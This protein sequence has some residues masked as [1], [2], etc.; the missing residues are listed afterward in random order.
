MAKLVFELNQSLDGYVDH[1]AFGP[2]DPALFRHFTERVRGLTGMV[3][4]RRMY[5]VMRY[6]DEDSP[7]WD[8]D[9]REY[10]AAWRSKPKWVVSRSLKSVGPK[11]TLVADDIESVIRGMK[12]ELA[13][14]IEV[15]GPE[16]AQ[17]LTDLGLVDEYRLYIHPVVLGRGKPFFAGPRPR[18]RL[19]A[20]DVI[21]EDVIRLT[22]VPA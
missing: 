5:E 18:L 20:S 1:L 4:G 16:L 15:A 19:V 17:S 22:Y 3:Y 11:A 10:A 8:A 2:P 6:W 9:E 21:V 13:G 14:E 12:A 7:D